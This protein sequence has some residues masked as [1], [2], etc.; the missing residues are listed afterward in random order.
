MT[1]FINLLIFLS[2]VFFLII[3]LSATWILVPLD[4][5]NP[6]EKT[7]NIPYEYNSARIRYLLEEEGIIR[8]GNIIFQLM[9]RVLKIDERLQSGE[10]KFSS[11]Q[12][13]L[14]IAD[15]L[16]KG[17]IVL[18]RITIPEGYQSKQIARLLADNEIAEYDEILQLIQEENEFRE[19]Y[20]FP[21]TYGFPKNFGAA[22]VLRVIRDNFEKIVYQHIKP[23]QEFP[24][25]LDFNQVMILAS[26]V[27]KEAQGKEDKPKIASVFY[28]RLKAGMRL[29]SCATIQY[30]LEKPQQNLTQQDLQI[31]SPFNT[32]IYSGLP[33]EPICNPGLDSILAAANPVEEEYIYFVLG[34][35]GEHIFSKTYQEHL[36]NKP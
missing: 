27:E 2:A 6:T 24:A 30:L 36:D 25:D 10:Y 33:P 18:H 23:E 5:V 28:N 32:Y 35:D 29:Q 11:S 19:G 8:P 13:L 9:T 17:K 1:R 31:E 22:N 20:L 4:T 21:D 12:N 7:L 3:F 16:V 14:Q 34:K 26:I 15:Q